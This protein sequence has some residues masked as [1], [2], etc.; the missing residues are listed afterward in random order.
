M[1]KDLEDTL[2]ELGPGYREVVDRLTDACRASAFHL[3]PLPTPS[4]GHVFRWTVG[5]LVAASL[6]ILL[7]FGVFFRLGASQVRPAVGVSEAKFVYTVAY[8]PDATALR[9]IVA[10]QRADG[11]W[12]NDFL[13]RQNAAALRGA[14]DAAALVAYKRA[15]RYLR[16]RGLVPLT[17]AELKA[18]GDRAARVLAENC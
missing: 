17:D 4:R 12:S 13:T 1:T 3:S 5:F 11:S 10:S 14:T 9:S 7:G 16:S 2:A 15:L 6:L 8:A 18:R